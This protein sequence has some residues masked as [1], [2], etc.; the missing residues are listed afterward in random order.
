MWFVGMGGALAAGGRS[1]AG[2]LLATQQDL[3][4]PAQADSA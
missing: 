3:Q 1:A 4:D 2:G